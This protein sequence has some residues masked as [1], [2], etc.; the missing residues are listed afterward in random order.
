MSAARRRSGRRAVV[1][2][3]ALSATHNGGQRVRRRARGRHAG[4]GD[5]ARVVVVAREKPAHFHFRPPVDEV[6]AAVAVVVGG[7]DVHK[8][9]ALV[10]EAFGRVAAAGV[11]FGVKDAVDEFA[12]V[13]NLRVY[14]TAGNDP[15]G[16]C[17]DWYVLKCGE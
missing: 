10:L 8:I 11:T 16:C 15:D 1:R 13:R 17:P 7:V 9:Q 3:D 14:V 5:V 4:R 12:A 6:G 2:L